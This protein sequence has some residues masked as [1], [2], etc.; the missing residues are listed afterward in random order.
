MKDLSEFSYWLIVCL[1]AVG[2]G[3]L[4]AVPV[5][6]KAT[7]NSPP[8][9]IL[10]EFVA[11]SMFTP[12]AVGQDGTVYVVGGN[13]NPKLYALT[14]DGVKNWERDLGPDLG[15]SPAIAADGTIYVGAYKTFRAYDANGNLRWSYSF[16]IIANVSAPAIAHDGTIYVGT[17]RGLYA[18]RPGGSLLWRFNASAEVNTPVIGKDGTIYFGSDYDGFYALNPDGTHRWYYQ[19][20]GYSTSAAIGSDGTVYVAGSIFPSKLFAFTPEG[21]K[22]WETQIGPTLSQGASAPVIGP[23]DTL[24]VGLHYD[25]KL[26]AFD[27]DGSPKSSFAAP[28]GGTGAATPSPA[29]DS[30]GNIYAAIG[31]KL[32]AVSP[33]G[34]GL[35]SS[36]L[37][38]FSGLYTAPT[39]TREGIIY[40]GN[41]AGRIYAIKANGGLAD[42]PWPM[43][44]RDILHTGAAPLA[45]VTNL[46]V[47]SVEA[48]IPFVSENVR[49]T[50]GRPRLLS[51]DQ[52]IASTNVT[53]PPR[54]TRRPPTSLP[55]STNAGRFTIT[56]AG[57][58]SDALS[59]HYSLSGTASNGVDYMRLSGTALF[60]AGARATEVVV[61]P[62]DDKLVEGDETVVLTLTR[63]STYHA[64]M[65][66]S[67]A[68]TIHDSHKVPT[69][70]MI[71]P[72]NG[73][74]VPAGTN[75]VLGANAFG[76]DAS[77]AKVEFFE[78]ERNLG[79]ADGPLRTPCGMYLLTWSNV[80]PG[81]YAIRAKATDNAGAHAFSEPISIIVLAPTNISPP[82]T[83]L[84]RFP[85]DE[86]NAGPAVG[87]DAAI[88][89]TGGN[90]LSKL[91]ALTPGGV[92]KWE[93]DLGSVPCTPAVAAD[94]TIYV[95]GNKM[96]RAF[97]PDGTLG[98]SYAFPDT[99]LFY[100]VTPPAIAHDGTIYV[101]AGLPET[102]Y[103]L[104]PDG[105]LKWKFAVRESMYAPIVGA[106]GT[107]YFGVYFDGF[108]ALAPD[109]TRKWHYPIDGYNIF[110]AIGEDGT[111]YVSGS[112]RLFAFTPDGVKKWE[113][114]L[115]PFSQGASPPVVGAD[116]TIFVRCD[117]DLKVFA[118]NP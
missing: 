81:L 24:Y 111:V 62:A 99:Y 42:T 113:A 18:L 105:S 34:S 58:S 56:R 76:G 37:P 97:N 93:T 77:V 92:K 90:P 109:G 103:A 52:G 79:I 48:T 75:I 23:D 108:Y 29:V 67:A 51:E 14:P 2:I 82:G 16:P 1:F 100:D 72:A 71:T 36:E 43:F 84:W 49:D 17:G 114:R 118:F 80:P 98:W 27:P 19:M 112:D 3:P 57:G 104:R 117:L 44:Q 107:I 91:Y 59:V 88:Y 35:W 55:P 9:T 65:S 106:D 28:R 12:P 38:V 101:G 102:L 54:T 78:G 33:T 70:T 22:I 20:S 89:V 45:P 10:W 7:N 30:H 46:P 26:Y 13:P 68:V 11:G 61:A 21:T 41:A 40:V 6:A 74:V 95:S 47:V 116:G 110:G 8:G 66:N 32:V 83:I 60:D 85:V 73:A 25:L 5:A 87:P 50:P 96:F 15:G 115:G 4:R 94:G 64:G 63:H 53:L 86:V 69:V 39:L 31:V